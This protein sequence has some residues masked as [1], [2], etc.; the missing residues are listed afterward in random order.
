MHNVDVMRL[1]EYLIGSTQLRGHRPV[2]FLKGATI[3]LPCKCIGILISGN[4]SVHRYLNTGQ[5]VDTL[6]DYLG[7]RAGFTRGFTARH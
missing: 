2:S 4:V 6:P 1:S 7:R 5:R 3:P